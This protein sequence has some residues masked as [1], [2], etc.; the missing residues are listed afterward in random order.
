[1]ENK[2]EVI[3]VEKMIHLTRHHAR[4][5]LVFLALGVV[6]FVQMVFDVIAALTNWIIG[7]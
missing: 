7:G 1:M 6:Q 2:P 3:K 4:L 5:V